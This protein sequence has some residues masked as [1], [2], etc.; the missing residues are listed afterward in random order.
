MKTK[1]IC[2]CL[3]DRNYQLFTNDLSLFLFDMRFFKVFTFGYPI[4]MGRK[5]FEKLNLPFLNRSNIVLSEKY[6]KLDYK[7]NKNYHKQIHIVDSI[8]SLNKFLTETPEC[9]QYDKI[10]VI[11][12]IK[13]FKQFLPICDELYIGKLN[14]EIPNENKDLILDL[15][16]F[17]F[18]FKV[19]E[20][21]TYN[22]VFKKFQK[23]KT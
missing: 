7:T 2:I 10:F 6:S 22:I 15:T 9:E 20:F 8:D 16:G 4:V 19:E 13:T 3:S 14:F 1:I 17:K 21:E 11:G 12:G 23:I 18:C 5:L